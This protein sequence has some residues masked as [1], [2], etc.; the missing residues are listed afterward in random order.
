MRLAVVRKRSRWSI[1]TIFRDTK[2]LAGLEA[3]QCW[4]DQAI[5]RHFGLALLAF[6]VLQM[7]RVDLEETVGSVKERWQLQAP[8]APLKACPPHLRVTA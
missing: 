8:P 6:T 2:Q 3:C 7:P 5:V 1:K 4:V